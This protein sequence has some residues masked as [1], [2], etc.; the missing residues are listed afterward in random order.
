MSYVNQIPA[1]H[2]QARAVCEFCGATS[3]AAPINDMLGEIDDLSLPLGWSTAPY[4]P[5]YRH[6]DGSV[7]S[8]YACPTCNARLTAG[9]RLKVRQYTACPAASG[10]AA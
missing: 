7:G 8:I 4:P 1:G 3:P 6:A 5:D 9:Q 10:G 2:G